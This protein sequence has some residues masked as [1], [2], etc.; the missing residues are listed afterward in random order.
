M[1]CIRTRPPIEVA[2]VQN[3]SPLTVACST[4]L[5]PAIVNR[6]SRG[7]LLRCILAFLLLP[8]A[9]CFIACELYEVGPDEDEIVL[10]AYLIS[11][12]RFDSITLRRSLS[13]QELRGLGLKDLQAGTSGADPSFLSGATVKLFD[14]ERTYN[15]ETCVNN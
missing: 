3:I 15:P 10:E 6:Q 1:L 5:S 7:L 14:L 8:L 2:Q 4:I 11:G 9:F 12:R 13:I